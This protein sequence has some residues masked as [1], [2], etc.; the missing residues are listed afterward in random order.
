[1]FSGTYPFGDIT[2]DFRVILEIQ[3]GKRPAPPSHHLSQVRGWNDKIMHLIEACWS[4][5]PSER[6]SVEVI[7]GTLRALPDRPVDNRPL[8]MFNTSFSSQVSLSHPFS[9][10]VI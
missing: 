5:K 3:Q 1:M 10:L 4:E 2:N 7:V 6:L 9:M 8:D